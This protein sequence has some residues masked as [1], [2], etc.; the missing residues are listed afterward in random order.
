M[1][2]C[3][4]CV[5]EPM[6]AA[7]ATSAMTRSGALVRVLE[8]EVL[9]G[10][11]AA[12]PA[13]QRARRDLRRVHRAMATR[14]VLVRALQAVLPRAPAQPLQMLELGAGD[15]TLM[16]GVVRVLARRGWHGQ[17]TL[18]DRQRCVE[19]TTLAAYADL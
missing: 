2:R 14:S 13:A 18:L 11:D 7:H 6:R 16:L 5:A 1:A 15:G 9:D 4:T 17:L 3:S 19:A 12:D 10:L 8:P